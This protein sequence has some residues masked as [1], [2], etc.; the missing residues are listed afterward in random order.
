MTIDHEISSMFMS[1][2]K[3]KRQATVG[4]ELLA[5]AGNL[6]A[7]QSLCARGGFPWAAGGAGGYPPHPAAAAASGFFSQQ[8]HDLYYRQAQQAAAAA[9]ASQQLQRPL[10]YKML[11]GLLPLPSSSESGPLERLSPKSSTSPVSTPTTT[12]AGDAAHSQ[13]G[14]S[15]SLPVTPLP[16]HHP[17]LLKAAS[18]SSEAAT[19]LEPTK[20]PSPPPPSTK[21]RSPSGPDDN[22][23][24]NSFVKSESS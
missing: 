15:P 17:L 4:I 10:P 14:P 7:V 3:W 18:P 5:E 6:A 23:P 22:N 24:T 9:A 8:L 13:R 19:K 20:S 1:R 16:I 12:A 11:P 21:T 2:T